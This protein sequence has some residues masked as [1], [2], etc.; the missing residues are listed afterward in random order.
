MLELFGDGSVAAIADRAISI[1]VRVT[2]IV[3]SLKIL[4]VFILFIKISM[5]LTISIADEFFWIDEELIRLQTL[6]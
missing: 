2:T 5:L 4:R 1:Q 3:I 6:F